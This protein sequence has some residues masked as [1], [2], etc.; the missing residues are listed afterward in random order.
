MTRAFLLWGGLLLIILPTGLL[1]QS[2]S[3]QNISA[4]P[5]SLIYNEDRVDLNWTFVGGTPDSLTLDF[6]DGTTASLAG[7]PTS[8]RHVYRSAGR[9][10]LTVTAWSAGLAAVTELTD[11]AVIAQRPIPDTNFMFLHHS[12]GRYMLRDAG[13]RSRLDWHAATG[14]PRIEL[15]DHDYH[16][17]NTYTG[18]ILP[19]ST[20]FS[21]WSYGVEANNIQ[22]TG[23]EAVFT[24]SAFRDSL[25]ARHDV[26]LFKNDH[27]TGDIVSDAQLDDYKAQYLVIRDILDQ[28]PEKM[29][30]M[31]SGPPRR[32][33]A[34]TVAEADRAR[35]FYDWLQSPEYMNG[36]PNIMFFDLFDLLANPN[37]PSDP[38]RNMQR[39]EYRLAPSTSTDS[40]P[41]LLANQ[42]IGPEI[43][44]LMIRIVD[45]EWIGKVTDVGPPPVP[46]LKDHFNAPNPFNPLTWIRYELDAPSEVGLEVFDLSGRLVKTMLTPTW[47]NAGRHGVSWDGTDSSGRHMSSGIYLY[48]ITAGSEAQAGR[49]VLAR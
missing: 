31:M 48:R 16:S 30:V 14:G 29:F 28:Y 34:I 45:P 24:G 41:N 10:D 32:P 33:T 7:G 46:T 9:F 26:I 3:V 47:Q 4:S 39:E 36:H 23:Y 49:M 15:W 43:A 21:D 6:H 22:P 13:V 8:H 25:F 38:E 42:T 35:R 19:D 18:I 40:H 20:V 17:G 37:D 12:T 5:T 27:S 1:A 2:V 11:F 44:E